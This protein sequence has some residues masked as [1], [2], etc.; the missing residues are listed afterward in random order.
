MLH[1]L[2]VFVW[3]WLSNHPNVRETK[4][5]IRWPFLIQNYQ[6]ETYFSITVYVRK[7]AL[8][9]LNAYELEQDYYGSRNLQS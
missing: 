2:R 5:A 8:L 1:D 7:P 9:I 3:G 4:F 6:G